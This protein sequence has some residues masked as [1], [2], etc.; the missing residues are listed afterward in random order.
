M[1]TGI[2][3]QFS[4]FVV[5]IGV[6]ATMSSVANAVTTLQFPTAGTHF[7]KWANITGAGVLNAN[8]SAFMLEMWQKDGANW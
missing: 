3:W 7:S 8:N 1:R 4:T 2:R 5:C 6:V